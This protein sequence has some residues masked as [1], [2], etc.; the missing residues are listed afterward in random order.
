[1]AEG[2]VEGQGDLVGVMVAEAVV[3]GQGDLV[4]LTLEEGVGA[5]GDIDGL[6]VPLEEGV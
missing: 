6:L 3:E 1:V 5:S 4:G 2:V